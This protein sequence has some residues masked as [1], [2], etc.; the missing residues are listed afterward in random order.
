MRDIIQR[1]IALSDD[2]NATITNRFAIGRYRARIGYYNNSQSCE[3]LS[4]ESEWEIAMNYRI[5]GL[6]PAPFQHL[7]GLSDQA[8]AEFGVQRYVADKN[9]TFPDRIEIRDAEI[10]ETLLL[11]NYT[12]QPANTPYRSSHAIFVLE[13]AATRYD[14]V[15]EIPEALRVRVLSLRAFDSNH[16]MIDAELVDGPQLEVVVDRLLSSPK[17]AYIQAHY[18]K[19]GCYAAR[20]E[21]A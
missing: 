13:G 20:I 2:C 3:A 9:L 1:R 10:G 5:T 18:A 14:R 19:R 6:S 21:R 16:Q 15:N 11:L 12:H 8:L 4:I 7:F 17:V